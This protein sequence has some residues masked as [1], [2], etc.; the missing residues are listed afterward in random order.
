MSLRPLLLSPEALTEAL[1]AELSGWR[2][3]DDGISMSRFIAC[4]S[5]SAALAFVVRIGL[6]AES[7]D[8]HPDITISGYDKVTVVLT[9]HDRGGIT[10]LDVDMARRIDAVSV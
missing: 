3:A 1:S 4:G 9:T 8:H 6:I 10:S 2:L 5:F 7:M